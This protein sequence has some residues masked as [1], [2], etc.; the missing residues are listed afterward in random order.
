MEDLEDILGWPL[1]GGSSVSVPIMTPENGSCLNTSA[2]RPA[3]ALLNSPA[4]RAFKALKNDAAWA[5]DADMHEGCYL[6]RTKWSISTRRCCGRPCGAPARSDFRSRQVVAD[7][8][9][10]GRVDAPKHGL[11]VRRNHVGNRLA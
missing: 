5:H 10:K 2:D 4:A 8:R 11:Y 9:L 1:S 3:L 6:L 7:R